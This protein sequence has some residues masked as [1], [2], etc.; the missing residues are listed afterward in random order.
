MCHNEFPLRNRERKMF[1][2]IYA[3]YVLEYLFPNEYAILIHQDRP[4]LLDNIKNIGIEVTQAINQES[5]AVMNNWNMSFC[6]PIE[7]KRKEHIKRVE[8]YDK[9]YHHDIK[10][11]KEDACNLKE[12]Y[13]AINHKNK[14]YKTYPYEVMDLFV[15]TA[16]NYIV[17][18]ENELDELAETV[19]MIIKELNVLYRYV[20]L[21]ITGYVYRFD[22][23]KQ[24]YKLYIFSPEKSFELMEKTKE[25]ILQ[26]K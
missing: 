14:K 13:N 25:F 16:D 19:L 22:T 17:E 8:Y 15:D 7:R 24:N 5:A 26:Q 23:M 10:F 6:E 21:N 11:W 3:K 4:D 20:Y 18:N 12:I 2:E 1:R 9:K